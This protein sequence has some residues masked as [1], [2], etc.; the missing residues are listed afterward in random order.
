MWR[1]C[2]PGSGSTPAVRR[3]AT[4]LGVEASKQWYTR[5]LGAEPVYVDVDE[6]SLTKHL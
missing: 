5:L 4:E 6:R 3:G 1:P 2:C